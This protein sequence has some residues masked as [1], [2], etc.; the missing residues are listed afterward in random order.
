MELNKAI[1]QQLKAL[2]RSRGL[3]QENLAEKCNL[4]VHHISGLERGQ[5]APSLASLELLAGILGVSIGDFF[6]PSQKARK[7]DLDKAI[8]VLLKYLYKMKASDVRFLTLMA[9]RFKG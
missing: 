7:S 9:K 2:R 5:H 6:I 1:G 8:D 3:T 4:S